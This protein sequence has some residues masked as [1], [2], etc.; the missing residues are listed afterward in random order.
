[1]ARIFI[2]YRRRDSAYVAGSLSEKLQQHFGEDSVF[3]DIDN[4]PLG[5]DFRE[6]IGNAVG[7]CDALLVI[8]GEE[9]VTAVDK[10]GGRRLDNPGDY[11]RIEIESALKRN[12]PIIPVLVEEA[13]MPAAADLPEAIQSIVYRNAAE[14]RAGSDFRQHIERLIRGL[15]SL[16]AANEKTKPEERKKE[17]VRKPRATA[18]KT[19]KPRRKESKSSVLPQPKAIKPQAEIASKEFVAK[20]VIDGVLDD[21]THEYLFRHGAIPENKSQNA[22]QAYA[23]DVRHE[24]ILLLYDNTFFRSAKDGLLITADAV[25]WHNY[26][27]DVG[28]ARFSDI[29]NVTYEDGVFSSE[30]YIDGRKIKL[31]TGDRT[32]STRI[33]ASLILSLATAIRD[34]ELGKGW[35]KAQMQLIVKS[36]DGACQLS[37]PLGWSKQP[38]LNSPAATLK[39]GN[40]DEELYVII[41]P[42]LKSDF[43]A[44]T[45]L[46]AYAD[47]VRGNLR[48]LLA[49]PDFPEPVSTIVG[50]FPA[51]QF[52]AGGI[53]SGIKVK[54]LYAVVGTLN[55]YY[56][57]MSWT[58]AENYRK[59]KAELLGVIKTFKAIS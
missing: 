1:M 7:Q 33:L 22:I 55:N 12:I 42:E 29:T 25:Y 28:T 19:E 31:Q 52:E 26:M 58:P 54:Y 56:Q 17:P 49:E 8:I 38:D 15:E 3:Y 57:I 40:P 27:E 20:F 14:I 21:F 47:L 2:S 37:F 34:Y 39:V 4:I 32:H 59:N 45:T 35:K 11:V 13:Q 9:W 43:D 5:V 24:D 30:I 41:I 16:F 6:H 46:D 50:G 23:Q 18:G 44:G 48:K 51:R 53:Y 36:D 10:N